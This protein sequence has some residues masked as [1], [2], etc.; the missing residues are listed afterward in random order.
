MVKIDEYVQRSLKLAERT[1]KIT[2]EKLLQCIGLFEEADKEQQVMLRSRLN[3]A[4]YLEQE[5]F[6]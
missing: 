6:E 3:E 4:K 5:M 1:K 2:I